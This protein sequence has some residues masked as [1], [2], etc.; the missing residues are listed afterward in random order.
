MEKEMV[1]WSAKVSC[2]EIAEIREYFDLNILI[3]VSCTLNLSTCHTQ[4]AA[5]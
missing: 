4:Q 5:C 1:L 3:P 2:Y